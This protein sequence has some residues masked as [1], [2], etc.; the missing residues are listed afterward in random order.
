MRFIFTLYLSGECDGVRCEYNS[1]CELVGGK[2]KCECDFPCSGSTGTVCGSDGTTY[3]HKCALLKEQCAEQRK[4]TVIKNGRCGG[5]F[6]GEII[7]DIKTIDILYTALDNGA[8]LL[9]KLKPRILQRLP[10]FE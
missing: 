2:K 7:H 6:A 8:S 9:V 3:T 10:P 4:I 1:T 5:E